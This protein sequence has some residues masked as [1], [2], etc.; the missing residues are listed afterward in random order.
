MLKCQFGVAD[1]D[2][3]GHHIC[4]DG[5][6]PLQSNIEA[7]LQIEP[8]DNTKEVHSFLSTAAYY[9]KFATN[10]ADIATPLVALLKKDTLFHWTSEC[11]QAFERLSNNAKAIVSTDA[12][13]VALKTVV[14][15]F[16]NGKELPIAF[17]S[18]VIK[19]DIHCRRSVQA[20]PVPFHALD[21]TDLDIVGEIHGN[22]RNSRYLV[23]L[24]DLHSKRSEESCVGN[25]TSAAVIVFFFGN[26]CQMGHSRRNHFGQWPSVRV[27]R[28][29]TVPNR[30]HIKHST[31][32]TQTPHPKQ[33]VRLNAS[34]V[35]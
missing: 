29:G 28:L 35:S 8:P 21:K 25:I 19:A 34:L 12:S 7:L 26:V 31:N 6:T 5:V 1:I 22:P 9:L 16:Q 18:W 2:F 23:V 30:M 32:C 20:R 17:A 3:A 15:Q 14:S 33:R 13:G 27:Q 11:Q 4:K 24:F 10:F